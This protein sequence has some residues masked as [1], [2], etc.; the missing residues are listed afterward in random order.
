MHLSYPLS[1]AARRHGRAAGSAAVLVAMIA[2]L[3][4]LPT[5]AAKATTPPTPNITLPVAV[6]AVPAGQ[7]EALLDGL[8]LAELDAGEVAKAVAELPGLDLLPAGKVEEAV[9]HVVETL[10]GEGKSFEQ[11]LTPADV[12]SA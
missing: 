8:P 10:G 4:A 2:L 1:T 7:L 9:T 3:A 12:V 11:L 6:S 5:A